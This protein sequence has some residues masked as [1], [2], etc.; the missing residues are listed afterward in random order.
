[1]RFADLVHVTD[2]GLLRLGKKEVHFF[3]SEP[4][5]VE[6]KG[7]V[8]WV[9]RERGKLKK[10]GE[11]CNVWTNT[12]REYSA[13]LMT[14]QAANTAYRSDRIAYIGVGTGAQT[15]E[16]GVT[17]L[18]TPVAY[19]TGQF[20][21]PVD[22]VA[23]SF[24]L[25]PARTSV[26]YSVTFTEGQLTFGGTTS[27]LVNELGLFTDGEQS[28]FAV[29]DRDTTLAS[30]AYQSPAA[31]KNLGDPIEKTSALELQVEWEIRF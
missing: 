8:R 22:I 2:S 31:Y 17:S 23:T 28:T 29:G 25:T 4:S 19:T 21:A 14:Y 11:G 7:W 16:A 6:T 12:G 30:A 27:V 5:V 3:P 26:R 13:M 18:V 24:P 9:T 20:L 1:M 15:E 10:R